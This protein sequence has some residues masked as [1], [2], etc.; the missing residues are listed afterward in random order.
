MKRYFLPAEFA[1]FFFAG[2]D[3]WG[4]IPIIILGANHY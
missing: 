4:K 1:G 2:F 3:Q